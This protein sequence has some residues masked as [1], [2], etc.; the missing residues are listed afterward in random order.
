MKPFFSENPTNPFGGLELGRAPHG[1]TYLIEALGWLECREYDRV[2]AG[3]HVV[4]I[5]ETTSGALLGDGT[6][7]VHIRNTGF[8]Y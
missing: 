4:I 7:H 6:P 8:S 5:G 1:G 2:R 3:D